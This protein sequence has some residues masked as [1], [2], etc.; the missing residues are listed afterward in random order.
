MD[1]IKFFLYFLLCFVIASYT[2]ENRTN[3]S[4]TTKDDEYFQVSGNTIEK[5]NNAVIL[6]G[7]NVCNSA[8][9]EWESG[10]DPYAWYSLEQD[11]ANLAEWGADFVRLCLA[12]NWFAPES[13][14]FA[15]SA[16]VAYINQQLTWA[17]KNN[18]TLLL[19]MHVAPGG[20]HG[21]DLSSDGAKNIWDNNKMQDQ[22]VEIWTWV[23]FMYKDEPSILGYGLLNEPA[24]QDTERCLALMDR[25]IDAI[26]NEGADTKH[27][28]FVMPAMQG[29]DIGDFPRMLNDLNVVYEIH[30][31][32][33]FKF[34]HQGVE[35]L[36]EDIDP[37]EIYNYP[38]TVTG[39][40]TWDRNDIKIVLRELLATPNN[41][42]VPYFLGEFGASEHAPAKDRIQWYTDVYQI[43]K[44]LGVDMIANWSYRDAEWGFYTWTPDFENPSNGHQTNETTCANPV[45]DLIDLFTKLWLEE[46]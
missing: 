27:I 24:T 35:W 46:K 1:Q 32:D 14:N 22:F 43:A 44:E 7:T 17:K 36:P 12:Y 11:Y 5:D 10:D 9:W 19:D 16:G 34:T 42:D 25:T 37:G 33:P 4:I 45:S 28:I 20:Y 41:G 3:F 8:L 26:R 29:Y 38:G 30:F 23:A 13:A 18:M 31:Y 6:N 15:D 21:Y 39:G 2:G 40:E